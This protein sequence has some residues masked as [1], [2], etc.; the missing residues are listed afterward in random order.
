MDIKPG[1]AFI[2]MEDTMERLGGDRELLNELFQVFIEEAPHKVA[3]IEQALQREDYQLAMKRAHAL[4]GS[5]SA[6]GA[7]LSRDLCFEL[8]KASRSED[9]PGMRKC[10]EDVRTEINAL[11]VAIPKIP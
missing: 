2:D 6:V 3:D 8:E 5:S 10:F 7:F 11:M 9:L 1:S 4:K